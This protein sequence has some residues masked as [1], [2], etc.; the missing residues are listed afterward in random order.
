MLNSFNRFMYC[1]LISVV[2]LFC[3]GC[4]RDAGEIF[5][6]ADESLVWPQP[7]ERPRIRYI[8]VISTE[9]DLNQAVS[10][11][12]GLVELIFGKADIGV[13]VGPYAVVVDE[14]DRL[15]S[16]DAANG[17]VHIFDLGTRGYSQFSALSGD[18]TLLMPVALAL[19]QEDIYLVDSMLHQVCVFDREGKFR[20]CFGAERLK[21]P[22]G[23]AYWSGNDKIYVSDA[24]RHVVDV[25]DK[26]GAFLRSIGSRGIKTGE[27]NFPTHLWFDKNGL[28][29]VSDTLNYRVQIFTSDGKFLRVIGQHGDRPGHFGH[30]CGVATDNNGN[31]YV[32]DRQFENVQVFNSD[33]N[34]LMAWGREGTAPGEF[35]LPAGLFIDNR[36]RI[37]VADSFNKRIQVFELLKED[38]ENEN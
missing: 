17:T 29:Y 21:R 2:V 10:W 33:G 23:I 26:N 22:S 13:L 38:I 24:G 31:I 15:F 3:H 20:F 37:Y 4:A 11:S 35:W 32:T 5:S 36:N 6:G 1:V 28:L 8:G 27:F 25:F 7:P 9:E 18:E 14:Q 12:Q 34:I 30:P 19:V 16:A